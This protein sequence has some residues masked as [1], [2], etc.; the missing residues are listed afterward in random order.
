MTLYADNLLVEHVDMTGAPNDA[1]D[2]W[3]TGQTY[4]YVTIHDL[5]NP[6]GNHNDAWQSWTGGVGGG[7]EGRAPTNL[8]I[9][10]STVNNVTGSNSHI[11]VMEGPGYQGWTIRSNVFSNVGSAGLILGKTASESGSNQASNMTN[12]VVSNN[13]FYKTGDASSA[14]KFNSATGSGVIADNIF[15]GSGLYKGGGAT[16]VRGY[17]NF[18]GA[19]GASA[20][21]DTGSNPLLANP[22]GGDFH[23]TASS[24]TVNTGDNGALVPIRPADRDGIPPIGV[25]DRGAYER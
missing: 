3:G 1:V 16:L 10:R 22:A 14:V 4:R 5:N 18:W 19:N 25:V 13:T 7:G 11:M 24:L 9:E 15:F 2:L 12:I 17:N 8:V 23:E 6:Y 20:S 21:T